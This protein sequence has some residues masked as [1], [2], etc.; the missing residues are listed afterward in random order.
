VL[1]SS[2]LMIALAYLGGQYF[3]LRGIVAGMIASD[4][5]LPFWLVPYLLNRYQ[6][7]FSMMFFLKELA[8]ITGSLISAVLMPWLTPFILL[9]LF[10]WWASSIRSMTI[11]E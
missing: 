9:L 1:G 3:G 5:L 10:A 2:L 8:P 6:E 11:L 4:L 7:R